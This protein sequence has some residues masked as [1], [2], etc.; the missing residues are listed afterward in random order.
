VAGLPASLQAPLLPHKQIICAK[1]QQ[2]TSLANQTSRPWQDYRSRGIS[3][4]I[5]AAYPSKPPIFQA[6]FFQSQSDHA[7][8]FA[9]FT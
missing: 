1:L 8:F 6:E 3:P 7:N 9:G 4:L 2:I 5:S